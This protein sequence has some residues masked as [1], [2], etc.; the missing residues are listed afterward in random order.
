MHNKEKFEILFNILLDNGKAFNVNSIWVIDN[1]CNIV[2]DRDNI[3]TVKMAKK[4]NYIEFTGRWTR[5]KGTDIVAAHN[6][7]LGKVNI[8]GNNQKLEGNTVAAAIISIL[9]NK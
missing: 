1:G 9:Y 4:G 8:V 3:F 7:S 2:I 5:Y 6:Y